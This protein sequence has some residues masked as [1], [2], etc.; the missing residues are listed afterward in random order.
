MKSTRI[1]L[2]ALGVDMLSDETGLP[3]GTVRSAD[4]VDIRRDGSF[5]RRDG[6]E[7]KVAGPDFHSLFHSTRGTLFAQGAEVRA[8]HADYSSHLVCDMGGYSP[9]DFHDYNG[10]TYI[11]NRSSFWW[12]PANDSTPRRVGVSPPQR[13]PDAEPAL[14]GTLTSG[15]YS[16]GISRVDDRDEESQTVYVGKVKL[17]DGGGIRLKGLTVDPE[18]KYRVYLTPPDGDVLYLSEE[19]PAVFG[20]YVLTRQPDGTIRTSQHLKPM[21]TGDFVRSHAGRLYVADGD[22]VWYSEALRPHLHNPAHNFIRFV[23]KI[24]FIEPITGG[25]YVGDDRGVWFLPGNEPQE[26]QLRL[27]SSVRAIRRSSIRLP[28]LHFNKDIT[29]TDRDVV[30]WLST[31]GY[32][33]GNAGGDAVSLHPERIRVAAALEGRSRFVIRDGIKQIITLVAATDRQ[34]Y[35]VAIDTTLQ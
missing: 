11:L 3:E 35:G 1:P 33:L 31:E 32:I 12:I 16:V 13:I 30:V 17:T 8:L 20:E 28:G 21:P 4:N 23:G 25:I 6:Y 14:N 15:T 19:L 2:P 18:S 5:K 22:T 9:V 24:R 7:V 26:F 27:I 10:N 34:T 29:Q